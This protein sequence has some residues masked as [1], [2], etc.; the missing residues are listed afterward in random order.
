MQKK[1]KEVKKRG[2]QSVISDR[3]PEFTRSERFQT[4]W[5]GGTEDSARAARRSAGVP[6][7]N[8]S[9]VSTDSTAAP[10]AT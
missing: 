5:T 9:S 3:I 2:A 1:R 4:L 7:K 10:A 6:P 8:G